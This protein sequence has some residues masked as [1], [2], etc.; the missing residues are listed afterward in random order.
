[1]TTFRKKKGKRNGKCRV[2]IHT[3][4][5]AYIVE[6]QRF[7][8]ADGSTG[9]YLEEVGGLTN[10]SYTAGFGALVETWSNEVSYALVTRLIKTVTGTA[11]LS[12][13]GVKSYLVRKAAAISADWVAQAQPIKAIEVVEN[14]SI[15]DADSTEVLLFMDDVGVKAQKPQKN[16]ARA[17]K[18]AKRL[19]TT[20]VLVESTTKGD[21]LPLTEGIDTNGQ[22]I[23]PIEQA[24]FDAVVAL[25]D[26]SKRV[27]IVAITDGARTIRLSLLAVFGA[28][29]C[30]ILDWYHLRL[31]VKNL[32]S[33]IASNKADKELY[34][35]DLSNLLWHG[36]V[37]DAL[38]YLAALPRVKNEEV[39][40]KLCTYIQKHAHEIIN[41]D[42]RKKQDKTIGSG[43]GEKI[44]DT[45]VARRQK[46]KGMAWSLS[47]SKALAVIKTQELQLKRN[48]KR[49][50][51][52]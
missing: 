34:I 51:A 48:Q 2:K 30:I 41:Y 11:Q 29:V 42:L 21:F 37:D 14:I 18:D 25:H 52:A 39:R 3:L 46:K 35:K 7:T 45:I 20:T 33:M 22:T 50:N 10:G 44:N 43:R 19:D 27:P 17:D 38:A 26:T 31:K 23:Y 4:T 9:S 13:S 36:Q 28:S 16:I 32:M 8:Y 47:G 12:E 15:Y 40:V 49:K 1:M 24:L 5:G 6:N